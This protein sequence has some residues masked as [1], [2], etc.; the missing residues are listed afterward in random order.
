MAEGAAI[1]GE[2][3]VEKDGSWLA[4]IPPYVS[5]RGPGNEEP[6]FLGVAHRP[7]QPRGP[8]VE[9]LRLGSGITMNRLDDR[10]AIGE[11]LIGQ[12]AVRRDDKVAQIGQHAGNP[13]KADQRQERDMPDQRSGSAR[14]VHLAGAGRAAAIDSGTS[15]ST[16]ISSGNFTAAR[17]AKASAAKTKAVGRRR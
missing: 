9:D 4:D 6:G 5:L 17:P 15:P 14:C 8:A 7:F 16:T 13:A 12:P 2:A 1:L 11:L 3:K 10:K